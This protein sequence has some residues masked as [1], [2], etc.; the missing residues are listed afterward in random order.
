MMVEMPIR[1]RQIVESDIPAVAELL[2]RGLPGRS[3]DFWLCGLQRMSTIALP[4][5]VARYGFVL[6]NDGVLV[7]VTLMIHSEVGDR[8]RCHLSSWYVAPP[9][10]ALATLMVRMALKRRDVTYVNISPNPKTWSTIEAQEFRR[11][12]SGQYLSIPALCR[13]RRCCVRPAAGSDD[14][15]LTDHAALGCISLVV[16]ADGDTYPFVFMVE[17]RQITYARVRTAQLI[18]CRDVASFVHFAGPIG[19]YLLRL[20]I[21]VVAHDANGPEPGLVGHFSTS[22]GPRY[23]RGPHPPRLGDLAYSEWVVFG[24]GLRGEG[25]FLPRA[26]LRHLVRKMPRPLFE[27]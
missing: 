25:R 15:V 27:R 20:N 2:L 7:G 5:G 14:R 18:Y 16:E 13:P 19:R 26:A 9:F 6:D 17:E 1:C 22:S 23:F 11:Y 21:T 3:L 24:P 4:P 12:A 10:R 8:L